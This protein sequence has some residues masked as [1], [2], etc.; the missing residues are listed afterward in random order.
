[1]KAL[2]IAFIIKTGTWPVA[3][4]FLFFCIH[5]A[6]KPLK[7]TRPTGLF[8][9]FNLIVKN[10]FFGFFWFF[11][12]YCFISF[13]FPAECITSIPGSYNRLPPNLSL[14]LSLELKIVAEVNIK[15]EG[16]RK[17]ATIR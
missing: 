9:Y 15:K 13:I 14:P 16:G 12:N 11:R 7:V 1:L 6:P 10:K 17:A 4:S 3:L 2:C 5:C 8:Q